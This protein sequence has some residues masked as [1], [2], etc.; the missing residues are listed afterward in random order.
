LHTPTCKQ[1]L[2]LLHSRYLSALAAFMR[3]HT[4]TFPSTHACANMSTHTHSCKE[5][6][7]FSTAG[8]SGIAA[9]VLA[10]TAAEKQKSKSSFGTRICGPW[11]FEREPGK[12]RA[13]DA[14]SRRILV[15]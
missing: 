11:E 12:W 4:Q 2:L 13:W 8:T 10:G 14:G 5:E 9:A 3:A 7:S 1:T 6:H 15:P